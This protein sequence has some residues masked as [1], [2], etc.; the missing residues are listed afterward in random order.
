MFNNNE[1]KEIEHLKVLDGFRHGGFILKE[2]ST[3]KLK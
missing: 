1:M 2:T 3:Q